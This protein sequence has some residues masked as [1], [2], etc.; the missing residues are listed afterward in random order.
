MHVPSL[1]LGLHKVPAMAGPGAGTTC[2][3]RARREW[4]PGHDHAEVSPQVS[5]ERNRAPARIIEENK[6]KGNGTNEQTIK[7]PRSFIFRFLQNSQM[8]WRI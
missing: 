4:L 1:L 8:R 5:M 6:R 3:Y 7:S 2:L